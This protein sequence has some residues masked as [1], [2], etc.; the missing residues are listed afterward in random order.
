MNRRQLKKFQKKRHCRRCKEARKRTIEELVNR[1]LDTN[2]IE[3]SS[4]YTYIL[5]SKS[6]KKVNNIIVLNNPIPIASYLINDINITI[7]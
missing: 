7:K 4:V 1:Y 2:N 3:T 5:V 6:Y